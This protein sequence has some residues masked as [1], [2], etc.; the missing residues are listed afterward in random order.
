MDEGE[1]SICSQ[2]LEELD[3]QVLSYTT[4]KKE[5]WT[6]EWVLVGD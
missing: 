5:T 4:W 2:T 1:D 6:E 3:N